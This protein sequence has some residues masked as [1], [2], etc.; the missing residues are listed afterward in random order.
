MEK[1]KGGRPRTFKSPDE[2]AESWE[3]YKKWADGQ[4]VKRV[5]KR[6]VKSGSNPAETITIKENKSAPVT[7]TKTAFCI[8]CGIGTRAFAQT[9]ESDP[10]F[11]RIVEMIEDEIEQDARRKFEQGVISSKLA[12]LWM[13][14]HGYS[15]KSDKTQEHKIDNNLLDTLKNAAGTITLVD[16]SEPDDTGGDAG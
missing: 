1:S 13:S 8:F 7:Y 14:K 4:T 11:S 5:T 15:L 16:D 12:G 10:E 3:E 9:Y 6:T 2:L